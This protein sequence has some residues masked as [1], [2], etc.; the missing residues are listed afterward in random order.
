MNEQLAAIKARRDAA[1]PVNPHTMAA[2][3]T[4]SI[5]TLFVAEQYPNT[6]AMYKATRLAEFVNA[7]PADIDTLLAEV[8]AQEW[9][10]AGLRYY[11]NALE[12]YVPEASRRVAAGEAQAQL[13]QH[14]EA[15]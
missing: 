8:T 3:S 11:V 9:D 12:I 4:R 5:P 1:L 15:V 10:L 6:E 14:K 13:E 7:A 2:S